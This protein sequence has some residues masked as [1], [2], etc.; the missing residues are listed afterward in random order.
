MTKQAASESIANAMRKACAEARKWLGATA[1]NPPVGAVALDKNGQIVATAA[2]H[3]AGESHAEAKLIEQCAANGSLDSIDTLCVTLEPCNHHGHT[4]PCVDKIIQSGVKRIAIGA[5]DPNPHVRGG[6]TGKLR[7]AG[8]EVLERV[9]ENE[10]RQLIHAFTRAVTTGKPWITVKQA[11]SPE[12]SMLPPQG[13]KTFTS[14][15]SLIL[16]HRL[17]KKA[18]AILTG[19]G[20]ILADN[21]LF[22]VRHVPDFPAAPRRVLA[23]LDR[24][25]RVPQSYLQFA[26]ELGFTPVRYDNLDA[27]FADLASRGIQ[28]ILVEAGPALSQAVLQSPHWTM[29]VEIHQPAKTGKTDQVATRFNPDA[30]L[31]FAPDSFNWE[32]FLPA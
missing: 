7:Q 32:W 21:P 13:Q 2:H 28:D 29:Q 26:E 1:P 14:P 18:G 10:C 20:T 11:F 8:I 9:E 31:P 16:A 4:P 25:K 3:K 5:Q 17:R 24:R 22:T 12:G 15:Q 19:S 23:I 27:A 6:G 30:S